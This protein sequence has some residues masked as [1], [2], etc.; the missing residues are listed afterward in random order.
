MGVLVALILGLRSWQILASRPQ[1][2]TLP[3]ASSQEE[4]S[5]L[6]RKHLTADALIG[7]RPRENYP[8]QIQAGSLEDSELR[9]LSRPQDRFGLISATP[10]P[11]DLTPPRILMVGD[12]NLMGRVSATENLSTQLQ[13]SLR[14]QSEFAACF[15]LNAGC[16][17]YSLYQ[18]ARRA[19]SL[20]DL[21]EPQLL[22][23]FVSAGDDFLE[24]QDKKRPHVDDILLPQPPSTRRIPDASS[25]RRSKLG[26]P[27]DGLFWGGMN[28]A[29]WMSMNSQE[30]GKL[31][32]KTAYCLN[33]IASTARRERA[34]SLFVLIPSSDLLFPE[35]MRDAGSELTREILDSGLQSKW[36]GRIR[37]LIE[38]EGLAYVDL[39]PAFRSYGQKDLYAD[40]HSL[41]PAGHRI[42]AQVLSQRIARL[43]ANRS[44]TR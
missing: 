16:E 10:L 30:L 39:E 28:Q 25:N 1:T 36:Y 4:T 2:I 3:P 19:V 41:G 42:A 17:D 20:M 8:M 9:E 38:A 11:Q 21:L 22:V 14:E 31:T 6:N 40:D 33:L 13:A 12:G 35:L 24:L 34:A 43:L 29:A 23:A 5:L 26:L 27:D 18:S 15:V 37:S 44:R 7:H 32:A